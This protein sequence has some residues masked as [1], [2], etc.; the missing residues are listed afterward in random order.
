MGASR[1]QLL[2]DVLGLA[3]VTLAIFDYFP[4]ALLLTPTVAAG[5]D[6]PCHYPTL[7][8]FYEH[9]LPR[10]RLHGWYP[11]AYLGHPLLLYY[12]PL[13]FLAMSAL[14]PATG[15]PVA[16]K[17]GTV[18]G[19]VLLPPLAYA[20]L[21]LMDFRFPAPLLGAAAALVFLFVE[22]NP[23][24]G[25]TMASTLTGEFAYA[26][27][28]ALAVL[29]LGLVYRAYARGGRL[30]IPA[31]AL[32]ATAFAHGYAVLWAGLSASFFLY[33]ARRPART[34]RWLLALALAAF[35]LAAFWLLP[36]L[37][38]W[39][40]TTP[41]DDPWITVSLRNLFPPLLW[42][43]FAAALAGLVATLVWG[44]RAGGA[45]RRLLF[46]AHAALVA[47]C[48]AVAGP[49]LGIIDVR[50]V[51]FAQLALAV[52]GAAALGLV[53][54]ALAAS[55]L[56]AL[57]LVLLAVLHGDHRSRVLRHW[58][59][60]NYT[61]LEAKELWP[62]FSELAT[63]LRGGVGDPRVAVEYSS[64]HEKAGSIRMYE[65]LPLFS[66]RPTLEGVY[67]QAS[68]Q[69][70]FVYY[71][72]S[73]LGAT[74]PNP[75][76]SRN[77]SRFD[78]EAALAH[79]R[80]FAAS[81]IVAL[82][83]Q[84]VAALRARADV[85][86]LASVP[87]YEVFRLRGP[88]P[89]YVE[90]M[91]YAP[92]RASPRGWR[93]E[94]WKWFTRRPLSPA[95]LVFSDDARFGVTAGRDLDSLPLLLLEPGAQIDGEEVGPETIAFRTNRPGHPVLVKVSYHPRW[96]A[97]GAD[98]PYLVSPALMMVVPRQAD[99]R[100]VYARTLSDHAGLALT[101]VTVLALA[102]HRRLSSRLL[103]LAGR[104]AAPA[105]ARVGLIDACDLPPAQARR[106][107]FLVPAALL[108]LLVLSR[109]VT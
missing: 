62:A 46:L 75:F 81:D 19:V 4:P 12:F 82:S 8:H 97:E 76:R 50:F 35:G 64:V 22:E 56:A 48:L 31:L 59:E 93:E 23:I 45:D 60:W 28:I 7:V 57:G 102:F 43:L 71:L 84:L 90:P 91:T 53:V 94:A 66:G 86:P 33:G 18:I 99:V 92:V 16:F 5:G 26:Y 40:S 87:P 77:Y 105:P 108:L 85:V 80:L 38:S 69:T 63:R 29:F 78:A 55:E 42:P 101:A 58:I 100:L 103:A 65:T 88:A 21:R 41:Y 83:P 47:A 61:G 37:G 107:G 9:L 51:P 98:G 17:L 67:N 13:P 15:L 73:E 89:R 36:L 106:W 27:G 3:L 11:G 10:L 104:V 49:A 6:T 79:L 95:H 109:L 96:R 44:R 25:G 30:W 54:Q 20:A 39:G 32:A 70:H 2:V 34:L 74:S 14:A 24:W 52:L 72:A 1:R 68:L